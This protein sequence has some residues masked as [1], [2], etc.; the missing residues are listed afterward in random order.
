MQDGIDESLLPCLEGT[1]LR[2][3][4]RKVRVSLKAPVGRKIDSNI[5]EFDGD[6]KLYMTSEMS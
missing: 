5:L 1:S 6:L 2:Q 4:S 3:Y